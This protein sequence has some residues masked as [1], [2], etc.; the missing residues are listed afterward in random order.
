MRYFPLDAAGTYIS[1]L[2]AFPA[3][4]WPDEDLG[5]HTPAC[6]PKGANEVMI[7][8][9]SLECVFPPS[10]MLLLDRAIW[11]VICQESLDAQFSNVALWREEVEKPRAE[12]ST[13]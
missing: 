4:R 1:G 11:T 2:F 13:R 6:R 7:S 3:H 10:K 12:D 8:P 5:F 9:V